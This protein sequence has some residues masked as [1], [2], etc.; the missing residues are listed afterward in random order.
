MS[1]EFFLEQNKNNHLYFRVGDNKYAVNSSCVLEI[2]KLPLLDYPQKLPNNIIGLMKYNDFVINIV[3]IRFYLNIEPE[4]YTTANEV[5]IIKTDETIIGIVVDKVEGILPFIVNKVD[6]LP[7]MDKK[8][9]IDA[10]Y[11]FNDET[12]FIIN[13][14][15]LENI[16]KDTNSSFEAYDVQS[17]FPQ[18][19]AARS[20]LLQRS[21]QL[22]EKERFQFVHEIYTKDKFISF[23]LNNNHYGI[24]LKYIKEVL[25]DTSISHVPCTPDFVKG[26]MNLR[27]DF[28]TVINLKEFLNMEPDKDVQKKPIIIVEN[29]DLV[30]ALLIDKINELFEIPDE[31]I[32]KNSENNVSYDIIYNDK[33]HTILNI[34][35]MLKDKRLFIT[36][37]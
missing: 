13:I 12:I 15:S 1:S 4:P 5:L 20:V 36:D 6:S 9:L 21:G 33:V 32:P 8:M 26:I 30:L 16:I 31:V 10:L 7:F 18:D 3:D 27:G 11:K 17:L 24:K 19:K 22:V 23:M 14:F 28:I 25:K 29:E 34:D 35:R 37:M 2:I